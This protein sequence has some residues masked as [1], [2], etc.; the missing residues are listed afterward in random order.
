MTLIQYQYNELYEF[1]KFTHLHLHTE[2]SLLD[3]TIKIPALIEKLKASGMDAC[4]IT[5]HGVMYGAYKFYKMM[6]EAGLKPIIGCEI[7]VAPRDHHMKE[8]GIDNKYNHMVLLAKDL[9]GY[10]NLIKI[11]S[12]SHLEGFYYKPR[13]DVEHL[14]KYSKGLIATSACLGGVVAKDLLNGQYD[15]A[16]NNAIMYKE[17]FPDRFYIEIQRNGLKEQ[18]DVNPQLLQVAEELSL[19]IV[20]TCDA[21]YLDRDDSM[22]QEILWCIADGKTLDDPT[23][24]SYGT[25]ELYLKTSEEMEELFSD[26]P[27]ALENTQKI[28][29]Q[30]EEFDITFG[31]VE[32][33]FDELPEGENSETF[34]RKL[35]YEGA[36]KKYGKITRELQERIDF[37]LSV[38]NDKGYNDYFLVTRMFV[39]FCRDNGIV[40]GMRG[41]G[42]GS[43]VAYCTDITH[44]EPISW[45]LYFERFLNPE[46]N[47]PPDFDLDIAD[48]RRDE[49]IQF[50]IDHFGEENVK[51]IGTFSKLQTR[52]AIRDV[53][54]VLGIDLKVA[55]QLSKMVEI[56]FGK[57]RSI[58][59]MIEN[60]IEFADLINSSPELQRMAEIVRKIAGLCRGVS[61]HA[62][63][64]VIT[65]T[66]VSD[67]IPLQR[68]SKNEGIGMTQYEMF[69]LEPVGLMKFDFLGL[70]N[71]AVIG[72]A[73][74]KIKDTRGIDVDL[75]S[76]DPND[77]D[78]FKII[79]RGHTV[80]IF[81]LESE[82]MR[83]TIK[84][85]K[86]ATQEE[87]CYLLAAYRPGPMQFIPEYISVKDGD[88]E[89][90]Y[91][92][93]ELE[94]ILRITNGVITYQEQVIRIAVDIAGY[95][96]GA[97]D[98]LRKAMGK[99]LMDVM[100]KEKPKFISGAVE[101]G[102]NQASVDA[103][104]ERLL[105]FANYGFNKAH[106]ASYALVSYWTGYL[107]AHYPL[108]FMAALL[109]GDLDNFD[110]VVID[111]QECERLGIAVLPPDINLSD[112]KF[113]IEDEENIR[114]G[115]AAIKNVGEDVIHQIVKERKQNGPFL[116]F[117]DFLFRIVKKRIQKRTI[118]YLIQAGTMDTLGDRNQL[119]FNLSNLYERYKSEYQDAERGQF[120]LFGNGEIKTHIETPTVLQDAEP[121]T[122]HQRLEW[123]KELLGLYLTSHPL[124]DLHDFFESKGVIQISR[125]I[126]E[127]PSRKIYIVG[128]I[129]ANIKRITTKK[130]DYMAFL[131]VEDKTGSIEMVVFPSSYDELQDELQ[132]NKPTLFAGRLNQ[133]DNNEI[134][135]V[136]EKA[137]VV[138]EEKHGT[139]FQGI[140][141]KVTSKHSVEEINELKQYIREHPGDVPVKITI[142]DEDSSERSVYLDRPVQV[143]EQTEAYLKKF[144]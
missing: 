73:L 47:S 14:R 141:F 90:E 102:F 44:L 130:G 133:R 57:A 32:P 93:P 131:T 3:G 109:E 39:K 76:V 106:S 61:T 137:K 74:E 34:L 24:R 65:P 118:E 10:K 19:P 29:E 50:A 89:A 101:K 20:A 18:D 105:Q 40:V 97:A 53:S 129:V 5:D 116:N 100:E 85:L 117:D 9:E 41:S 62:C 25:Q 81:Q 48:A 59:Y 7:Y 83:K 69:D 96:M 123:E 142:V 8:A 87:I 80:G 126:H 75:M 84:G 86:P 121:T 58:D 23:R 49:V 135:F 113:T 12:I 124:D 46:R 66:P 27:E 103:L 45:E 26:L 55:D 51:Q 15:K 98:M 16:K 64:V 111:L 60:N 2:Y 115:M 79:Q 108:E 38:I 119:I 91:L 28:K 104:W 125:L 11:L 13:I 140:T 77:E 67:Y 30:I 110:R 114:F 37:E 82:G 112:A 22:I 17:M 132:P 43:V 6:K 68:D 71:L 63:G 35:T 21:H 139:N 36:E 122:V 143:D 144:S 54:R 92:M 42:C 56:L 99:K 95:S 136:L 88:K 107:K 1:M 4:A 31:R 72:E 127:P 134:S 70:R 138:D 94:P 33:I 78:T 52:Q 128:G 120:D